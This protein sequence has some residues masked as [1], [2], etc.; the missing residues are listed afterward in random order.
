MKVLQGGENHTRNWRGRFLLA[1]SLL[2]ANGLGLIAILSF[3][4]W[5][6]F[7]HKSSQNVSG[8]LVPP[9][10]NLFEI[11]WSFY[12]FCVFSLFQSPQTAL[13]VFFCSFLHSLLLPQFSLSLCTPKSSLTP[14]HDTQPSSPLLFLTK[15]HVRLLCVWRSQVVINESSSWS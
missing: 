5:Q 2:Q 7:W 6:S 9:L 1:S 3:R 10:P 13:V 4:I 8:A 14:P 15:A 11:G 12:F